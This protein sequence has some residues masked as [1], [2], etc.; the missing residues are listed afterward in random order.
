MCAWSTKSDLV[1]LIKCWYLLIFLSA[2]SLR[3]LKNNSFRR[4]SSVKQLS[5]FLYK[6]TSL[7]YLEKRWRQHLCNYQ[8]SKLSL[9]QI[10]SLFLM[11]SSKQT[12]AI[13]CAIAD[14]NY[15]QFYLWV[16]IVGGKQNRIC[17]SVIFC[18]YTWTV[19]H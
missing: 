16:F 5:N 6:K 19:E 4:E 18:L 11:S 8:L 14:D 17:T 1:F 3:P 13:T 12:C 2:I 7:S 15:I 9:L 10:Q